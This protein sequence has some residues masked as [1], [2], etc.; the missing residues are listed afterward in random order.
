MILPIVTI[1]APKLHSPS[2]EVSAM[3]L[4][5]PDMIAF[6]NGLVPAMYHYD[7]IGIAAPQVGNNVQICVIGKNAF[8]MRHEFAGDDLILVN[9]RYQKNSKKVTSEEEG[10]LSVPGVYGPVKRYKDIT[11]QALDR[12]GKPIEFV[13][14]GFLARVV[15]HEVDHLNG[16]LF[17]DRVEH[18]ADFHEVDHKSPVTLQAALEYRK[19]I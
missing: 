7:G 9:P 13:A 2:A 1:P 18:A 14:K 3:T 11:V 19:E 15:Q 12:T 16:H 6:V 8:P 5:Q 4:K 17:I 10:C